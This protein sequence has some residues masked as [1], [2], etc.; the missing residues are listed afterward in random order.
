VIEAITFDFWNTLVRED[1]GGRDRTASKWLGILEEAGFACE[2]QQWDAAAE[3]SWK[4]FTDAWERN[5]RY[6]ATE[7][8]IHIVEHLGYTVPDDVHQ[9]LVAIYADLEG[10]NLELTPGVADVLRTLK[11][12]GLRIGIICDVGMTPSTSLRKVLDGH[13]VLE[14]FDHWSFSDEVGH[15]KPS[16]AIFEYALEGLGGVAPDRAAH[17]GDLRRTDV[18]GALG[19]GMTALRYTG[20]FDDPRTD[21][22]EAHHVVADHAELPALLGVG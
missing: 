7:A 12:A 15:F 14:L 20:V 8:A 17:I 13:G 5:E 11:G 19:M 4:R 6:T 10:R 22:P 18:A 16:P 2:R 21:H 3:A 1:P 9:R